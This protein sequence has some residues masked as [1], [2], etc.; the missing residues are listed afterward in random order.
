MTS[1]H[2]DPAPVT[3]RVPAKVNLELLVGPLR[4]DGFHTLSTVY[5]AV[6]LHDDVTVEHLLAHRSGIGDYLDEDSDLDV[7][8]Y[9]MPVSVHLLDRTEAFLPL[10]DGHPTKFRAGTDFAYCNGGFLVLALLAWALGPFQS[11]RSGPIR[12]SAL[13]VSPSAD[14]STF[15]W[16]V[17]TDEPVTSTPVTATI[18]PFESAVAA[19]P[20]GRARVGWFWFDGGGCGGPLCVRATPAMA[21]RAAPATIARPGWRRRR[22]SRPRK[23]GRLR[24]GRVFERRD[25]LATAAS[26]GK[27]HDLRRRARARR[28]PTSGRARPTSPRRGP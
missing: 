2:S 17:S 24:M 11:S 9:P 15:T 27:G 16:T 6:S 25:V 22:R 3:V 12:V 18:L 23:A 5:Q 8:D 19:L 1:A 13:E 21:I 26:C 14:G 10:L 7:T 28:G 4:E 20:T